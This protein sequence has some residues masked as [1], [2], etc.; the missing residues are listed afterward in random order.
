M[1]KRCRLDWVKHF[2]TEGD[3]LEYG[4]Y[5]EATQLPDITNTNTLRTFPAIY[6]DPPRD[7]KGV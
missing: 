2:T 4:C 1:V 5:V 7:K 3:P 6:L